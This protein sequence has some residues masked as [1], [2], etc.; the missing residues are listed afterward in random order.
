MLQDTS[1]QIQEISHCIC[2]QAEELAANEQNISYLIQKIVH[3]MG[4][5][6]GRCDACELGTNLSACIDATNFE[7]DEETLPDGTSCDMNGLN[8]FEFC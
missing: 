7:P 8:V 4:L 2:G 3:G 5:V 1:K 6:Q